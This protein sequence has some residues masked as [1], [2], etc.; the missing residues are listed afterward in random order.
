MLSHE[1]AAVLLQP[2]PRNT[3]AF[4]LHALRFSVMIVRFRNEPNDILSIRKGWSNG[5]YARGAK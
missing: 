3:N 5:S 1:D 4:Y 2:W